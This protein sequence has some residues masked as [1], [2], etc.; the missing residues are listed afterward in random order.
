M[1][2]NSLISQSDDS[3]L[4]GIDNKSL[5]YFVHSYHVASASHKDTLTMTNFEY[6]FVSA[7]VKENIVGF[8]FHPE[9]SHDTGETLLKNF[10]KR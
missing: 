5:F 10:L 2:W 7:V 1:G 6:D 3:V 9:K 4:N 8:Q